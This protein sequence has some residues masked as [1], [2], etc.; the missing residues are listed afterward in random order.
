[1][2]K[3]GITSFREVFITFSL[4]GLFV[5]ATLSFG[6]KLQQDNSVSDTILNNSQINRTLDRLQS[7]LTDV[8]N[9]TQQQRQNFE[10]EIPERGFGSLLIFSIV[11]VSQKF[12]AT[13]IGVYN[14]LIVLPASILGIPPE[15]IGVLGSILIVSLIL[16][17]WRV[18]RVGS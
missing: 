6:I 12:T 2:N 13:I 11:S 9:Q 18:Y 5:L 10:S 7:N 17:A 14:I 15:V 1:M 8:S 16:L 4:I 3:K